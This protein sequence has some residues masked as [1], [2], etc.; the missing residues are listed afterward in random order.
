MLCSDI[1]NVRWTDKLG[2][3]CCAVAN[4]ED[5]SNSGVCLQM[6]T[7]LPIDTTLTISH[8]KAEF[9]GN[10]RYCFFREIGYFLG[11]QF[12]P[13]CTWSRRHYRPQHLL[14]LRRLVRSSAKRAVKK[15]SIV[16]VVQ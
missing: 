3:D 5:I 4:L 11:V 14:D 12:S 7:P 15:S 6:D 9:E 2:Q 1:V 10:V 16:P 8:P 13:G